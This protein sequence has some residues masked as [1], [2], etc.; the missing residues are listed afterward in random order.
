MAERQHPRSAPVVVG[1]APG[2]RPEVARTAAALAAALGVDLVVAWADPARYVVQEH[3]DGS[4]L[5]DAIDPES[6]EGPGAPTGNEALDPLRGVLD[7]GGAPWTYRSLAGEPARALARLAAVVGAR[8]IVVGSREPGLVPML[9][10]FFTGSVA[11]QLTHRQ[12]IPV[13]VVPVTV[14]STEGRAAWE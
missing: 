11:V 13:L 1:V 9:A 4:V 10:E 2:Q 14:G 3:A 8:M 7:A 5:S 6:G 12:R